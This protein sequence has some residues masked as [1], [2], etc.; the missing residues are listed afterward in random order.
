MAKKLFLMAMIFSLS[1][2]ATAQAAETDGEEAWK[3]EPA[4]GRVIKIGYN[5]GLCLGTF[6][7]AHLMGFYKD[8]GLQTEI[9]R[10]SGSGTE[11]DSVGTGKV[12]ITGDHIATMLVP[13]VNG[14]RVVFTTGI[15]TGCKSL[16][17]P[18]GSSVK[19]TKDLIGK[20][21]AI[22][23]PIGASDHNIA[24]RFLNNDG[25]DP[26]KVKFKV[27]DSGAAVLAMQ[28]GEIQA[29]LMGDQFAKRFVD[30]GTLRVLRSLTFD[31][32]FKNETC[33]IHA[34]SR[35]FYEKNPMTVKKL[36]RAQ[37]RAKKFIQENPEEAVRMLQAN[38]WAPGDFDLV[39]GILKTYSFDVS[40][41]TTEN[42]L[43]TIINDY[44]KFG[45]IDKSKE[46][47]ETL[48]RVW[49]PVLRDAT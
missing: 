42:T 26:M 16:Y 2:A 48:K 9:V 43:R 23:D 29:A 27:T 45:L 40:D 6:G 12:D 8:E 7:I 17:V 33:C 25:I 22:H 19:S 37:E 1:L 36:T 20:T 46:T 24:I 49:V 4:S 18:V 38:N 44:K 35:D 10:M 21:V 34:V 39:L 13:T 28:K 31:D 5:G 3:K 14:V 47:E 32:D 15:H 41:E 30:D 11:T